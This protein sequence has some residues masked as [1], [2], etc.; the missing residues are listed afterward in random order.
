[1]GTI[2]PMLCVRNMKESMEFYQKVL[3]FKLGMVFP[4]AELAEYADLQKDG[5]S[6]M[7]VPARTE[8]ISSRAK[9]GTGV[10]IYM[11][12]DGDIDKYHAQLKK[13]GVRM[14]FDIKDEPYGI[15]D[16]TIEDNSGYRLVFNQVSKAGKICLSCGMPMTKPEDFGGGNAENMY[17]V[18]CT[19]ASGRLKSRQ[20]V[21]QGMVTFMMSSQKL[22][23]KPAEVAAKEYM[24]KMPAWGGSLEAGVQART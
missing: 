16:F 7:F 4:D 24:G 3:G 14:P 23:R 5:M 2:S 1:M 19:D 11:Q 20:E 12:I 8:G 13:K 10:Y 15:R 22:E 21:Y 17:C 6:I 9:L 18:N